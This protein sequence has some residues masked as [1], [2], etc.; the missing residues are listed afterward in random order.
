M[1][2]RL[3]TSYPGDYAMDLDVIAELSLEPRYVRC[4]GGVRC[5]LYARLDDE[6][7]ALVVGKGI[8]AFREQAAA[9]ALAD[10]FERVESSL[11][12]HEPV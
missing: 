2:P 4:R 10:Y 7:P 1:R 12:A 5:R 8:G 6:L 3:I 9:G 11:R